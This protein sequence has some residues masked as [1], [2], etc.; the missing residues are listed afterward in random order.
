[1]LF[2]KGEEKEKASFLVLHFLRLKKKSL[3]RAVSLVS[4]LHVSWPTVKL[5]HTCLLVISSK[6]KI[7]DVRLPFHRHHLGMF[8]LCVLVCAKKKPPHQKKKLAGSVM[9]DVAAKATD[10]HVCTRQHSWDSDPIPVD[11]TPSSAGCVVTRT[12]SDRRPFWWRVNQ[13][14]LTSW[15]WFVISNHSSRQRKKKRNWREKQKKILKPPFLGLFYI[16]SEP[17]YSPFRS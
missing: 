4:L 6:V 5:L 1:L 2:S 13:S 16:L 3:M 10:I 9:A 17:S 8:R 7:P 12:F 15:E 14:W 11:P